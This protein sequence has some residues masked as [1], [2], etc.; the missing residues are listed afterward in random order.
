MPAFDISIHDDVSNGS[1]VDYGACAIGRPQVKLNARRMMVYQHELAHLKG[2]GHTPEVE[3]LSVAG[4][5][6]LTTALT[7]MSPSGVAFTTDAPCSRQYFST[8]NPTPDGSMVGGMFSTSEIAS[9][10]LNVAGFPTYYQ[11]TKLDRLIIPQG[12]NQQV[13]PLQPTNAQAWRA[14]PDVSMKSVPAN[15]LPITVTGIVRFTLVVNGA[16]I[17]RDVAHKIWIRPVLVVDEIPAT[18][19]PTGTEYPGSDQEIVLPGQG[20]LPTGNYNGVGTTFAIPLPVGTPKG[21]TLRLKLVLNPD[22]TFEEWDPFDNTVW[23]DI[24]FKVD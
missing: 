15:Q 18:K 6:P 12:C 9:M 17:P 23:T 20:P 10:K 7:N 14:R 19:D 24:T 11:I 22:K 5:D 13:C 21:S 4:R 2:I 16:P 1:G 3:K 8:V